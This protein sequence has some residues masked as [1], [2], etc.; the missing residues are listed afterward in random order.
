MTDTLRPAQKRVLS[1][2]GGYLAVSAVPGAGKTFVLTRLAA[3][4]IT[5]LKVKPRQILILTYMRSAAHTFKRRIADE[6][7]SQGIAAYGLQ[8]TTFHAFCLSIVKRHH[9]RAEEDDKNSLAILSE[10]EQM[11]I[12]REGLEKYLE[13][14]D[15]AKDWLKRW[16]KKEEDEK[17][18]LMERTCGAAKTVISAAKNFR[19]E[20]EDIDRALE[21][22]PEF[23]FL[24][25]HYQK[26]L[27]RLGGV[28]YDDQVQ[29]AISL[30]KGDP[31]LLAWYQERF[32]FVMEDEAQDS[33]PAQHELIH[34]LTSPE[35]GG[36][37]NLVRVGDSNQAIMTSFT[38]NDPR[39]FREFCSEQKHEKMDESSRSAPEI[40]ALANQLVALS[41]KRP[42]A[43]EVIPIQPA[44]TGGTNPVSTCAP[45]W[46]VYKSQ[47]EEMDEILTSA[48]HYLQVFPQKRAAILLSRNEDVNAYRDAAIKMGLPLFE[49]SRKNPGQSNKLLDFLEKVLVLLNVPSQQDEAFRAFWGLLEARA[50]L[51]GERWLDSKAVKKFLQDCL[52]ESFIY[53]EGLPPFRPPEVPEEDYATL[54]QAAK[55]ARKLLGARHLPANELLP[56]IAFE[57][58][59]DP[60]APLAA[61]KAAELA[62]R[63]ASLSDNEENLDPL[64]RVRTELS[65]LRQLGGKK[66]FIAN[67]EELAKHEEGQ[68]EILT[69]H[70]SKGAEFGAVWM[71]ALTFKSFPW[72]P[73]NLWIGDEQAFLAK[74][75]IVHFGKKN[76]PPEAALKSEAQRLQVAEKLRLLYVG[77]TRAQEEIHLSTHC[78]DFGKE[79]APPHLLELAK[80]CQRREI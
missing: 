3:H 49:E 31:S 55:A 69:I 9:A 4:L 53:P 54:V 19:L 64:E 33:T 67:S 29:Q 76:A 73:E 59:D 22:Q 30:I 42:E 50:V 47:S 63:Q 10:P 43:F 71:P 38:F 40:L 80:F 72:K 62:L 26:S 57:L 68:L 20:F 16:K 21:K 17:N 7:A 37:G 27:E 51:V 74:Q 79:T 8:A 13:D 58:L 5:E 70:K 11:V 66:D 75:R 36:Q 28:D 15:Q 44:T 2:Q 32:R 77:I 25:R 48:R 12:L 34:L 78:N 1:Y 18:I 6:L 14:P 65:K 45:T 56:T 46:T 35:K 39:F 52:I 41:E 60:Q 23:P 61:A 24:Y